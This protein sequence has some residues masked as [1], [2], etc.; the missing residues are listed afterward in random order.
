M[1]LNCTDIS[2]RSNTYLCGMDERL[3]ARWKAVV[4][5]LEQQFGEDIDLE[6]ILFLIGI[7]E[8]QQGARKFTKD[9]K[10]DV[11]HIAVC[12]LLAPYG[13]YEFTGRDSEGWPHWERNQK[14]PTL[15]GAEQEKL[16]REA[17]A[18]YFEVE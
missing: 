4:K 16:M 13:Y 9:Q 11:L 10:L 17:I 12:T 14:L 18:D 6:A 2:G 15:V 3:E 8:L 1:I 7:Q 5:R